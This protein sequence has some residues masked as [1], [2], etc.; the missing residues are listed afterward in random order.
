MTQTAGA[1]AYLVT[2][3][4]GCIG[5]WTVRH[6]LAREAKVVSLDAS[7]DQHRLD[8][9][10]EP[11]EKKR[12]TFVR[13]SITDFDTVLNTIREHRID[14]VIHLAALQIPFCKADPV[15]GAN[16]NVVGTVN[17]LEAARQAGLSHVTYASS[18]AAHG[19]EGGDGTPS[20]LYGVYKQAN[21]GSARVYWQDHGISSIG[22][23]PYT[24]YGVARDQGLT[25]EPT[26]AML[27]AAAGAP[28]RIGFGGRMQFHF[29]SDVALQFIE[30]ADTPADGAH[31]FDL[32]TNPV[33]VADVVDTIRRLRPGANISYAEEPLPF[34]E[35]FDPGALKRFLPRTRETP[36]EEGIEQTIVHF[37]SLLAEGK[38]QAP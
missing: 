25:S 21:E 34:P 13:G 33:A 4:L 1:P 20:T 22:L 15:T 5:A 16:V 31:V 38:L 36:L 12:I 6:L 23:R 9:L 24:V 3:A 7:E 27:A 8:L 19:E 35:R 32:G 2:G 30:A 26:G 18:I 28:Y 37:E 11:T 29:A 10:L 14:R 17:V